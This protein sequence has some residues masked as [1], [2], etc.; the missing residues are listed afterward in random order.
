MNRIEYS[1]YTFTD[2]DIISGSVQMENAMMFD[3]LS[4]D[5]LTVDVVST[6]TGNGKLYTVNRDWYHT[7]DNRGYVVSDTD[8]RKFV[9]GTPVTYYYDDVL[10]G[11]FYVRSVERVGKTHFRINAFSAVG[12]WTTIQ[13]MGGVYTGQTAKQV[14]DD[15]LNGTNLVWG[16]GTTGTYAGITYTK[17]SANDNTWTVNGTSTSA[18][19]RSIFSSQSSF[20]TGIR[21]GQ[22]YYVKITNS[23]QAVQARIQSYVGSTATTLIN[24]ASEGSFTIPD[25]ATGI[26]IQYYVANGKTINNATCEMWV[27]DKPSNNF[28]YTLDPDVGKAQ[29]Y[30]YLPIAYIRDNLQQ[31][32]FVLGASLMKDTNGN[33]HIKYLRNIQTKTVSS[34]RIYI[35]GKLT[36]KTPATEVRVTEHSYYIS[37]YDIE[38][39]LFDNTDGSG[40]AENKLVT[41]DNPCHDLTASE[42]LTINSSGVNHA[43]VTGTGTL[44]GSEYTHAT[45]VFSVPTGV[46]GETNVAEINKATLVSI[47][48]SANVAARVS[49]YKATAEEVNCGIVLS[50]DGLKPGSLITFTDPY[51]D[52]TTGFIA[53][54]NITMSGKPKADCMVIK[55]Y[56][57]SHFGN[58]YTKRHVLTGVNGTITFNH[59]GTVR[60]ILIGGGQGG[61]GGESG[62]DTRCDVGGVGGAGGAGGS[63][64]KIYVT[65]IDVTTGQQF[66]YNTGDG[67]TGG[68]AGSAGGLGGDT[69][70]GT[71]TSADGEIPTNG[72]LD[73]FTGTV[74]A[75]S[76]ADGI[77]G[78][79]GGNAGEAGQS[80][81]FKGTTYVG[82]EGYGNAGGGG[83]AWGS[84]GGD[85]YPD[86]EGSGGDTYDAG[87]NGA[88]AS[89]YTVAA[90][91]GCGGMGGNGGGGGGKQ[92]NSDLGRCYTD[93]YH[94]LGGTGSSGNAGGR[95]I[96]LIYY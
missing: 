28:T 4:P 52:T 76:G 95:G 70:F 20:P 64:G 61:A 49:D 31:V 67:G 90:N 62:A 25:D 86:E 10:Q 71:Y 15:I 77:D 59:T 34:D 39:S 22:T 8:I 53:D 16:R 14:I 94:S 88:N 82:G 48:N 26:A 47:V 27:F 79:N 30:G 3:T 93:P 18:S 58:N 17:S 96:I 2:A 44:I 33:P 69:T 23:G 42:G 75:T 35:G 12:L 45:K 54:M 73:I 19:A 65:D 60:V 83:A 51:D 40:T 68:S 89:R 91:N 32:L 63:A 78:G 80:V 24:T 36:Y 37:P 46:E 9:Y 81:S 43:Y 92:G 84:N 6:H 38:V 57:P 41:F 50:T 13:H 56:T 1:P 85:Y 11:K 66:S 29:L 87:G 7:V 5:E 72:F 55:N 21:K 74:Y